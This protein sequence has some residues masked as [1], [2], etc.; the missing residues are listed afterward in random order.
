MVRKTIARSKGQEA[1]STANPLFSQ[2]YFPAP[3]HNKSFDHQYLTRVRHH[4]YCRPAFITEPSQQ[5]KYF[6]LYGPI[7]WH[8]YF[9]TPEHNKYVDLVPAFGQVSI[10]QVDLRSSK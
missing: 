10:G 2:L 4:L 6:Y 5:G 9:S 8:P 7:G 3:K 1:H